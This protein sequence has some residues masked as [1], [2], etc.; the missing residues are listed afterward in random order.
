LSE[1]QNT[2][3]DKIDTTHLLLEDALESKEKVIF[4]FTDVLE[5]GCDS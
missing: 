4:N 1:L 3:K 2:M 5:L